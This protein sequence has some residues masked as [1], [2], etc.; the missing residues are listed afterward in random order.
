MKALI[1]AVAT[2]TSLFFE[3]PDRHR[4]IEEHFKTQPSQRIEMRGFS[5]ANIK[6]KSWEK[7]EVSIRLDISYSSSD[8]RDEQR[9]LDAISLKYTQS[10]EALTITY[11]EADMSGK[12]RRSFWSWVSS[13]FSGGF[14]TKEI[15][16]EIYVPQ[17]NSL[18][19]EVRYGSISL[20]GM[21]GPL[22]L[23]GTG[24]TVVLK[25]CSA[26]QEITNDYGKTTIE[27]SGGS[28]QLSS[29]SATILVDQFT[30]K[31]TIDADYS[32]ITAR[33]V[34]QSLV[35][36]STSGT[37]KVDRVGGNTTIRSDYSNI[38]ANDIGGMLEVEDKSGKIHAK[39]MDGVKVEGDYSSM[40]ISDVRGKAGKAITLSGQSSPIFL[41]DAVGE[42]QINNPYG[43]IDL[44]EIK[45]SVEAKSRS[46]TVRAS[47]VSGDW[48]S[49]TEYCTLSLRDV[50]AKRVTMSNTGGQIDIALTLA[51]T[52][53]DI[54]NEYAKVNLEI[55]AGFSGDVDLNVTYG[56]IETNLPLSKTKSFDGGGGYAIGK[57][58]TGNGKLSIETKS[59]NVKV[60]QR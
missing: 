57:I 26:I 13:I 30:G 36:F 18:S 23:D 53:V 50:S 5:G 1:L 17:S 6:V 32:N 38:T 58:G 16:G 60:M 25:N 39:G 56:H 44:K 27:R 10:A 21:K 34:T 35:I 8:V 9:F 33:D 49:T 37:I 48:T 40:E 45:G 51:P 46:S 2:A 47:G 14:M 29:K 12:G 3:S 59:G 31:A 22:R 20:D 54:K 43:T 19:A 55:P 11:Y 52:F 41:S 28:L 24:N 15:E 4:T 7:D 42:V